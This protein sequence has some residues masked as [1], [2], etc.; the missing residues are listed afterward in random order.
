MN[1]Y[2]IFKRLV[3]IWSFRRAI[4]S[5]KSFAPCGVVEGTV[6]F[7]PVDDDAQELRYKE[8]GVFKNSIGQELKIQKE[9]YYSYNERRGIEKYFSEDGRKAGLFYA[10][11]FNVEQTKAIGNHL[12]NQDTYEA[13]Y[14]FHNVEKVSEIYLTYKVNGPKKDDVIN[15]TFRKIIPSKK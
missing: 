5:Q 12:C 9:Y 15:T 11:K 2:D 6:S 13:S 4:S 7:T 8:E 10:L 1:T 3:G 14:D